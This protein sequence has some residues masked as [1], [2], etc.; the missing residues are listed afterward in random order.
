MTQQ[1]ELAAQKGFSRE[2][3]EAISHQTG[4]PGWARER[5]LEA[6]RVY[7]DTSLPT[8]TDEQWRRTDL[9]ALRL[10]AVAAYSPSLGE[11]PEA[12][13][14]RLEEVGERA[15][16]VAQVNSQ[17]VTAELSPELL[18]KGVVFTS[19]E[20]ALR[21]HPDLVAPYLLA[22]G[23][24]PTYNKFAALNGAFWSAGTFL[25]VPRDLVIEAPFVSARWLAPP[26]SSILPRTIIL[27]E[28]GSSILFLEDSA[29]EGRGDQ[30]LHCGVTDIFLKEGAQLHYL[31]V[32]DWSQEVWDFSLTRAVLGQGSRFQAT[33]ASLGARVSRVHLEAVMAGRGAEALLRGLYFGA[34]NQH[35]DFRT[36]QDHASPSCASNLLFKGALKNK[37]S[38][39]YEGVVKVRKGAVRTSANQA[40]R[41][42]LLNPGAKADSV[43]VLE[44]EASDIDRCSHGA[45]V[46]QVDEEQL[47]YLMSRGLTRGEAQ[48]LI[49]T[50]FFEPIIND[51]PLTGLQSRL[52]A[53]VNEKLA[54]GVS[55]G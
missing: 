44:I 55:A 51:I 14:G 43:P 18:R 11:A 32:Q 25:Y 54:A 2:L 24:P 7:E 30:S 23:L 22:Q 47:H 1:L 40:N 4:E 16:L 46:G 33:L 20:C 49:V 45:T 15:G 21:E 36:L 17:E 38:A 29:S 52:R 39:A 19:L 42:L 8:R 31:S 37:A 53:A 10:E 26:A 35:F 27:M 13:K 9:S 12:L 41:N 34:G 5:R 50:G 6:W 28:A 3:A 48:E